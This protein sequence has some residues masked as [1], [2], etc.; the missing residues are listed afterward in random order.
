[1]MTIIV[2]N[3]GIELQKNSNPVKEIRDLTSMMLKF[4]TI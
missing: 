2:R 1:M 4:I 3:N